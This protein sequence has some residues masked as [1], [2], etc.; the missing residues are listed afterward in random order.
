MRWGGGFWLTIEVTLIQIASIT[1]G[2]EHLGNYIHWGITGPI[3][4][5]KQNA[6][7]VRSARFAQSHSPF[8]VQQVWVL[9][10]RTLRVHNGSSPSVSV[11]HSMWWWLYLCVQFLQMVLHLYRGHMLQNGSHRGMFL[12]LSL[13]CFPRGIANLGVVG[14]RESKLACPRYLTHRVWS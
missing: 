10:S 14:R 1:G 2:G 13:R 8:S 11:L 5:Q 9:P 6:S 4:A 12:S 3:M 7:P